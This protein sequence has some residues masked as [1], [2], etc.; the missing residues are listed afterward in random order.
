MDVALA[1][2]IDGALPDFV[3]L[4]LVG[5]TDN[6]GLAAACRRLL[7]ALRWFYN[8][9]HMTSSS[10]G[11]VVQYEAA[12]WDLLAFLA[13]AHVRLNPSVHYLTNHMYEDFQR[14]GCL[15]YLLEESFEAAHRVAN[16]FALS[17]TRGRSAGSDAMNS[18]HIFMRRQLAA[19]ALTAA[20]VPFR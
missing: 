16:D 19:A 4:C 3:S 13:T 14:Y 20:G 2:W 12:R 17:T 9:I 11:I 7:R 15:Y 8:F 1:T 18:W 6:I 10:E 5:S